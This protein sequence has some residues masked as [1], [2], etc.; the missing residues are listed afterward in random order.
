ML[1]YERRII[2]ANLE[3]FWGLNVIGVKALDRLSSIVQM[4]DFI[5]T[6]TI[7][8]PWWCSG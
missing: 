3:R 5:M 7:T 4:L 8:Q 2:V 6:I 1:I